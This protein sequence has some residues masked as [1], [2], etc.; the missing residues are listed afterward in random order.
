MPLQC[1][2]EPMKLR[3][4]NAA[5]GVAPAG[6]IDGPGAFTRSRAAVPLSSQA[7]PFGDIR[8]RAR[9]PCCRRD[10]ARGIFGGQAVASVRPRAPSPGCSTWNTAGAGTAFS[11][12]QA[13]TPTPDLRA[14]GEGTAVTRGSY[15]S[16]VTLYLRKSGQIVPQASG[17]SSLSGQ[18]SSLSESRAPDSYSRI[19]ITTYRVCIVPGAWMRQ[20]LFE[21]VSPICTLSPSIALSASRR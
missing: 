4:S 2:G 1:R 10:Q 20:L 3:R 7:S 18:G 12:A 5:S 13:R 17:S 9:A 16:P 8:G 11:D 19:G 21:S 14:A 15:D 6:H